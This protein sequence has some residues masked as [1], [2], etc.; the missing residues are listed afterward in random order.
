MCKDTHNPLTSR[1]KGKINEG[2]VVEEVWIRDND[3]LYLVFKN[4]NDQLT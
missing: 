3:K 4:T 2:K 1:I